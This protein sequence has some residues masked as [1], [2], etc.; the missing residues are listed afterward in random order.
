M[1]YMMPLLIV[2]AAY[3]FSAAV[4]LYWIT[5]NIFTIGQELYTRH[6]MRGAKTA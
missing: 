3:R 6:K 5:S 2:Y 1:L 4:A